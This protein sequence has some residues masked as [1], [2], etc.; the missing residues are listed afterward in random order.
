MSLEV[1]L[2][3]MKSRTGKHGVPIYHVDAF[4]N[5]L[6]RGNPAAV[7]LLGREYNDLTL[8]SVAAEMNLSETAF[9]RT[10]TAEPWKDAHHFSL[11][12]FTP[13]TEVPLCGHATLAAAAVLFYDIGVSAPELLFKTRSGTLTAAMEAGQICLNFPVNRSTP[14]SP[15]PAILQAMG[16]SDF[17][18]AQISRKAKKLLINLAREEAVRRLK[19]D[20]KRLKTIRTTD[21]ILGIIATAK[22][23]PPYDFVSRFF[24]PWIG[25]NEDP[26]TGAAHTVLAPY[27]SDRLGKSR[28][29]AYQ[30]SDRG[31]EVSVDLR[32]K[33]RVHLI[34]RAVMVSKGELF[35]PVTS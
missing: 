15:A 1:G 10:K 24:A 4:T 12:W 30:V 6:F 21:E 25:I 33:G 7:C 35:L 19:P 9:L 20:F 23:E 31:G 2:R 22:G 34:G 32:L 28:M 5:Q 13:S 11:R 3:D 27:W 17:E 14:I 29:L 16:I 18:E 8:Q 26:V